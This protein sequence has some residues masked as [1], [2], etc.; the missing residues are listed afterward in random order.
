MLRKSHRTKSYKRHHSR[1]YTRKNGGAC[2]CSIR[3]Q[4]GGGSKSTKK[5]RQKHH[6]ASAKKKEHRD[7]I[8]KRQHN[9]KQKFMEMPLIGYEGNNYKHLS[10]EE[11][12]NKIKEEA[13]SN[14]I[15]KYNNNEGFNEIN[16][17]L[18]NNNMGKTIISGNNNRYLRNLRRKTKKN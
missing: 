9:F 4:L 10:R 17:E 8:L 14:Y 18:N 13:L 16:L 6:N 12:K 2:P 7:K 11:I 3:G 1:R 5:R 15:H